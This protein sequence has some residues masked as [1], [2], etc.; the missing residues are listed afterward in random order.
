MFSISEFYNKLGSKN[1]MCLFYLFIFGYRFSSTDS[2]FDLFITS[3]PAI[4]T[5]IATF[6]GI[7]DHECM[8]FH[9]SF[10]TKEVSILKVKSTTIFSRFIGCIKD[11]S[12]KCQLV[13]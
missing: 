2:I 11:L 13:T 8:V 7:S 5:D 9:L 10:P 3:T 4:I 1:S 6:P 12:K